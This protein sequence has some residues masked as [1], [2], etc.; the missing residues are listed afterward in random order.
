MIDKYVT[1]VAHT[2]IPFVL[3]QLIWRLYERGYPETK[4]QDYLQVFIINREEGYT[5]ITMKQ[6][7]SLEKQVIPINQLFDFNGSVWLIKENDYVVMMLPSD[8]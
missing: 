4:K 2:E 3:Q 1:R 5:K 8:Y 6:E 7:R